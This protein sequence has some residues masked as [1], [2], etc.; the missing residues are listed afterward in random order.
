MFKKCNETV[1]SR[2]EYVSPEIEVMDVV[3]E[4]GFA[5]SPSLEDIEEENDLIGW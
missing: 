1:C 3:V 4:N 5:S 2:V